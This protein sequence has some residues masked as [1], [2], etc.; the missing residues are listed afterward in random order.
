MSRFHRIVASSEEGVVVLGS[1]GQI[2][3]ANHSAEFLLGKPTHELT[4]EVFGILEPDGKLREINMLAAD[5]SLRIVQMTTR[6]LP[7][8]DTMAISLRDITEFRQEV[9]SRDEFLALLGHELRNP[10]GAIK[11]ASELLGMN[12][13]PEENRV[14][15]RETLKRQFRHLERMLDDLLELTRISRGK[16]TLRK[17]PLD[18]ATIAQDAVQSVDPLIQSRK[19]RVHTSCEDSVWVMGDRTRLQQVAVNL[20]RNAAKYTPSGGGLKIRVDRES[21]FAILE[22][23]DNGPGIGPEL[24]D[25]IFDPFVQGEPNRAEQSSGLG[26][27][28][29]LV[30]SL[31]QMHAG[32]VECRNNETEP[33]SCFIARIPLTDQ[34]P[35]QTEAIKESS[36]E[37]KKI[38]LVEDNPD[39]RAMMSIWLRSQGHKVIEAADGSSGMK[40][41]LTNDPDLG[42]IDI[43]LPD[44]DGLELVR[45][46]RQ[47]KPDGFRC[48]LVALSGYGSDEDIR[49]SSEV[50]FDAHLT[51]P[52]KF[53]ELQQLIDDADSASA[54]SLKKS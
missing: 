34:R 53:E 15:A 13:I 51:K 5:G 50:G 52:V 1:D 44:F 35:K 3:Y 24:I 16:L 28:L 18:L 48:R 38:L 7:G 22:V 21:D 43:G 42:L 29:A 11:S 39:G 27:G 9:H 4:G 2:V 30:A 25:R 37:P 40:A 20:L 8:E 12:S 14:S 49:R 26:I 19:H 54:Q 46:A 47:Q 33:G 36:S 41:L 17:E 6:R 45:R 32:S 10:L 23:R 31:V